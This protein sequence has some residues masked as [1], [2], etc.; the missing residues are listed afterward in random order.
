ML[1][2]RMELGIVAII[3]GAPF[4]C[5]TGRDHPR[6]LPQC[7]DQLQRQVLKEN[8]WKETRIVV[9][10]MCGDKVGNLPK[11]VDGINVTLGGGRS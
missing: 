1:A 10:S 9:E 3:L 4:R 8:R 11:H 7:P 5:S 6:C 2:R